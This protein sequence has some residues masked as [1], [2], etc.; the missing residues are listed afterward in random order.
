MT[1]ASRRA[2]TRPATMADAVAYLSKAEEFLQ[3]ATESLQSQNRVAATSNAIH[4][5]IAAADAIAAA[6]AGAVWRGEHTQAAGHLEASAGVDGKQAGQQL[7]RLL[8]LKSRAEYD[9]DPLTQREARSAVQ[10][11]ERICAIAERVVR[12]AR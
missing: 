7:R 12:P 5:G 10:A 8:L 1:P 9:P 11:A 2:R 6:R 4:A 3:A